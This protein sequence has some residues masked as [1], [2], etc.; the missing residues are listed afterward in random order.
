MSC[1]ISEDKEAVETQKDPQKKNT[2]TL[3]EQKWG[4]HFTIQQQHAEARRYGS[5]TLPTQHEKSHSDLRNLAK[6]STKCDR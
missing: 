6:L 5:L 2:V 4:L 3:K 1:E